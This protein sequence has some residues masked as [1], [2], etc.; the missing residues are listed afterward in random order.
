MVKP[1]N[2]LHAAERF[3]E[4]SPP[5]CEP[6]YGGLFSTTA[7]VGVKPAERAYRAI[8]PAVF[9]L[10]WLCSGLGGSSSEERAW[11][12]GILPSGGEP[13]LWFHGASAGEMAAAVELALLLRRGGRRFTA[14]YTTTNR[15]GLAL[16]RSRMR[17]DDVAAL[18]PWDAPRWVA[19]AL[20]RWRPRALFLVETELWPSLVLEAARRRVPVLAVSAR[21]YPRDVRRYRAIR[22][23]IAP[24]LQRLAA[25]VAQDEVER[26]RFL[27]L[28]APPERCIV[29]GSLK[30][31]ALRER[32]ADR[33]ERGCAPPTEASV[34]TSAGTPV[35]PATPPAPLIVFGS[36][37]RDEIHAAFAGLDHLARRAAPPGA[38]APR[39]RAPGLPPR[40]ILAPRRRRDAPAILRAAARR[41]WI[42]RRASEPDGAAS[43][44]ILVLDRMGEL[45]DAYAKA[46]VAVVG[47]SFARHGGHNPFEPIAMGAPVMLGPDLAHF[48][49]DARRLER[50][51]PE[52]FVDAAT[53]GPRLAEWLSDA[54]RRADVLARQRAALPDP[55][56]VAARYRAAL[57]PWLDAAPVA[58]E[59]ECASGHVP[60]GAQ[61]RRAGAR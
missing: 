49:G 47:G 33:A 35:V 42:A 58:G 13:L 27:S 45:L 29:G 11:R 24:T 10:A 25:I 7:R 40:A 61:R 52:A 30:H 43:W 44:R 38:A 54:S 53:L 9:G 60:E 46:T 17:G 8:G 31:L 12:R 59:P 16:V 48:A 55:A 21:I 19:R 26:G 34:A 32:G 18:A 5:R 23:W 22:P 28:G 20:D 2:T 14:G 36:I 41:G 50:A 56:A 1:N 15:A 39:T 57:G 6:P 3:I 4:A 51:T 37:H